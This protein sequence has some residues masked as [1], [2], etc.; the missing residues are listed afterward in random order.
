M[1]IWARK[2]HKKTH[3]I[4]TSFVLEKNPKPSTTFIKITFM[5]ENDAMW[6]RDRLHQCFN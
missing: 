5:R 6:C 3:E 2:T 1:K 4:F